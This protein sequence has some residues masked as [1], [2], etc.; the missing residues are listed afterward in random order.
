V[1]LAWAY[2]E[3]LLTENSRLHQTIGKVDRLCGDILADCS[4]EVYE[5]NMVSLTDDLEDLAKFLEVHQEKI[6][7]LAGALNK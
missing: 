5:A 6:K 1:D 2:I 4:R 7:L 3:L